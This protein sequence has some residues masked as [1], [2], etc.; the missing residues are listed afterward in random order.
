MPEFTCILLLVQPLPPPASR[1][2]LVTIADEAAFDF[3]TVIK[4]RCVSQD[5]VLFC[6]FKDSLK[7][8]L[9]LSVAP[10]KKVIRQ[11]I[12]CFDGYI[13]MMAGF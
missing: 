3:N 11:T 2:A 8:S 7:S 1:I 5:E 12:S 9:V 13:C 10:P 4:E 6:T